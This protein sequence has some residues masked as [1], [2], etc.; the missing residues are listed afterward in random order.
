MAILIFSLGATN[1][2]PP[3][4]CLGTRVMPAAA[5]VAVARNL[6]RLMAAVE[7]SGFL[8][9]EF[10]VEE[11]FV[12]RHRELNHRS[13]QGENKSKK[14]LWRADFPVM[15]SGPPGACE[16]CSEALN[17]RR[18]DAERERRHLTARTDSPGMRLFTSRLGG[19]ARK[20]HRRSL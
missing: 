7:A 3:R 18:N 5:A 15:H 1:L 14:H 13:R 16:C 10:I 17:A 8:R 11:V 12:G 6:R 2:G 20:E 9:A 19:F 4:T